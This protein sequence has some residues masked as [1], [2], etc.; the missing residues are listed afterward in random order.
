MTESST[1]P[2]C[3]NCNAW[4]HTKGEVGECLALPPVPL[5]MGMQEV[6]VVGTRIMQPG[7]R[8]QMRPHP[9]VHAAFPNMKAFGWCRSWQPRDYEE[10]WPFGEPKQ[11]ELTVGTDRCPCRRIT[12]EHLCRACRVNSGE[13]SITEK[14]A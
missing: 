12:P 3:G 13:V 4:R 6:P 8:P 14:S 11:T 7:G 2:A 1:K 9:I 5:F 10:M